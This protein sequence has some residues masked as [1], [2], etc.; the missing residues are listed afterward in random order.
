MHFRTILLGFA[1]L[2]ALPV[3]AASAAALKPDAAAAMAQSQPDARRTRP[4]SRPRILVRPRYFPYRRY[5]S[6]YPLP[7]D[8]EY[9]G[10]NAVRQCAD[11]YRL[12]RRPSGAVV[13]PWIRCRWVQR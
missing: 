12:E 5:H 7:Y 4:Y 13:T 8:V 10:P 1:A 3:G 2:L 11:G 6:V 9:P